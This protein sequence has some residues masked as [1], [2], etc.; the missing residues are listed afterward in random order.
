MPERLLRDKIYR[1]W[2]P[3]FPS[4]RN[5]VSIS[6]TPTVLHASSHLLPSTA[7]LAESAEVPQESGLELL[8]PVNDPYKSLVPL[9]LSSHR[10]LHTTGYR[11]KDMGANGW[12]AVQTALSA[13]SVSSGIFPPLQAA[14]G[15]LLLVMKQIDV[16]P[17]ATKQCWS[18]IGK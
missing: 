6:A 11:L 9:T 10:N 7:A 1:I 13:V 16:C 12:N 3:L 4:N 8:S 2:S 17:F 5:P 14:V 15:G 18:L